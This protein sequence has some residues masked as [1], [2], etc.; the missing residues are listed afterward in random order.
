MVEE[1]DSASVVGMAWEWVAESD[2]VSV[3][4]EWEVLVVWALV[5]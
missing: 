1:R 4:G 2:S 3:P 5:S